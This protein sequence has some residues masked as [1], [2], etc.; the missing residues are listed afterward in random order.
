MGIPSCKVL[1]EESDKYVWSTV[2]LISTKV[3]A[4]CRDDHD[5]GEGSTRSK[6]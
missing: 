4:K 3:G 5:I 6:K 2:N 1:Y